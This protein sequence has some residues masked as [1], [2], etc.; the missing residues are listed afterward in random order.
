MKGIIF[1]LLEEFLVDRLGEDGFDAVV[2]DC[3]D[4]VSDPT[5]M[6]APGTYPDE[7]FFAMISQA[8][9]LLRVDKK[10]ML[11][12][13]G[14]Y[15]LPCLARRYPDFF[16]PFEHPRDF[17]KVTGMV[18]HV[19]VRKLYQDARTPHFTCTEKERGGL[20]L[21]YHSNRGLCCFVEGLI[22][23]LG[24]Y[25]QVNIECRQEKC[26]CDGADAC[27]FVLSFNKPA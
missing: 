7:D 19:E 11:R 24:D 20:L 3:A 10:T 26:A 16:T 18:H 5:I 15:A 12:Q 2:A 9:I 4:L 27:E 25:Y 6:V 22:A 8:A 23:G 14:R 21:R 13:F 17:L 1:N